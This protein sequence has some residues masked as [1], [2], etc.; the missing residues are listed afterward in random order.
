[1]NFTS[2]EPGRGIQD[3][4]AVSWLPEMD[5]PAAFGVFVTYP[6]RLIAYM[7]ESGTHD[8][9]GVQ[10][11]S[12]TAAICGY[13]A[14]YKR[15]VQFQKHWGKALNRHGVTEMHMK[16]FAHSRGEFEG[17]SEDKRRSLVRALDEV[18]D[19]TKLFALGGLISVTDYVHILPDWAKAEVKHPFYFAV[20]VMFKSLAQW[21]GH[22]P[23]GKIDFVLDEKEG[24]E[25]YTREMFSTLKRL[26]PIHAERLGN[27]TFRSSSQFRP[28]QAADVLAYEVRRSA[29]DRFAGKSGPGR[30]SLRLLIKNKDVIVGYA[31]EEYL[32][33]HV[34]ARERFRGAT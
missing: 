33:A 8:E 20:A 1:M 21:E 10:P 24:F 9:K 12:D 15:W 34:E 11:G 18:I 13:V 25:G 5:V 28:L 27:L 22:L 19:D 2:D 26:N 30:G 17:W 14:T 3:L 32:R 6:F 16:Y 23:T 7:D 4:F 29:S 31:D